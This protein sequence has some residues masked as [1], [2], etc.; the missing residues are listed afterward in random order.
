MHKEE[1]TFFVLLGYIGFVFIL[2]LIHNYEHAITAHVI[3]GNEFGIINFTLLS[4][5]ESNQTINTPPNVPTL[6]N[7]GTVKTTT[8]S[9]Q[10]TSGTDIDNDILRD[11]LQFTDNS[12]FE[13]VLLENLNATS[14]INIA[15]LAATRYYYWRVRTCDASNCSSYGTS[16][17]LTNAAPEEKKTQQITRPSPIFLKKNLTTN[18]TIENITNQT[19]DMSSLNS[20]KNSTQEKTVK[21]KIEEEK[22]EKT[23]EEKSLQEKIEKTN[24]QTEQKK[25]SVLEKPT[26][27]TST[28]LVIG[29]L[30]FIIVFVYLLFSKQIRGKTVEDL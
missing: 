19:N 6:V 21:E 12:A 20:E 11:E 7:L 16:S 27:I 3:D 15:N 2:I 24:L 8:I 28:P 14:P 18:V 4:N 25:A 23:I 26:K 30:L 13:Y 5:N 17:L 22:K 1:R 9:L 29:L 10:W